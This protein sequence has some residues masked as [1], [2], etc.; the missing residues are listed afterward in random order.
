M[1]QQHPDFVRALVDDRQ[2]T[3][4]RQFHDAHDAKAARRARR[5]AR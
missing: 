2:A 3:V 1:H 4:R 5:R